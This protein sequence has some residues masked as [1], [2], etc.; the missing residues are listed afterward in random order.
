MHM[1]SFSRV[2]FSIA[3][4][5]LAA[6]LLAAFL[7]LLSAN[8]NNQTVVTSI[9]HSLAHGQTAFPSSYNRDLETGIDTWTDCLTIEVATYGEKDIVSAL[10]KADH[11]SRRH[12]I[13]PCEHLTASI[14]GPAPADD[15][16]DYW[17]YWWGS[18]ALLNIAIGTFGLS[19]PN[20][21]ALLKALTYVTISLAA[22][23]AL[24]RYRRNALPLLPL[25]FGLMF[26]FAVPLFGQSVA[27][28][29]GLVVGLAFVCV[30]MVTGI[31]RAPL[32]WQAAYLFF[33]GGVGFFFDI[34]NGDIIAVLLSFA[35]I[36]LL[37]VSTFGV[38]RGFVQ[39]VFATY[40]ATICVIQTG[41][42]Y[43][44]GAVAL[45]IFRICLRAMLLHQSLFAVLVEWHAQIAKFTTDKLGGGKIP[46][47]GTTKEAFFHCY[48]NIEVATFPYIG[49]HA[50]LALYAFAGMLYLAVFLWFFCNRE[51][52]TPALKDRTLA[53][54]LVAAVVPCWYAA[55]PVHAIIHFW[56]MGRLLALFFS[57]AI[58]V[59]LVILIGRNQG[60]A[61]PSPG[62]S[63]W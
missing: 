56:M 10:V 36:R 46:D 41:A 60:A 54:L 26:G 13:H 7:N 16:Q 8:V 31:D 15:T 51:N 44:A 61:H 45:A 52:L 55:F 11:I 6:M 2:A 34:L 43:A 32:R 39:P 23:L 30:Y 22:A 29:P 33:A 49:R 3:L 40:P 35:L 14:G 1:A 63:R 59:A 50:T 53:A 42:A 12:D 47:V 37:A 57:L 20:Y 28:A 38:P 21:Q 24:L 58:S 27:H 18:A 25:T 5:F 4:G 17:R 62:E 9:K 19:L 48:Y